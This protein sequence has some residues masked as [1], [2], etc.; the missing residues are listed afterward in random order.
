MP[1]ETLEH[2]LSHRITALFQKYRHGH[3]IED[4][5]IR[6]EVLAECAGVIS[7]EDREMIPE[8]LVAV[9]KTGFKS[10]LQSNFKEL[11]GFRVR[12]RFSLAH[13]IA[14]TFFYEEVDGVLKPMRDAPRGSNLESA[15]HQAAGLLLVPDTCLSKE[16]AKSSNGFTLEDVLPLSRTFD[17]S[18]EVML[19]RLAQ[20]GV[21]DAARIAPI[22]TRAGII[23]FALYPPELKSCLS[24]PVRGTDF[25][26]WFGKRA[27]QIETL[28]DG[29]LRRIS[30]EGVV[31]AREIHITSER[32]LWELKRC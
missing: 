22:L 30:R 20:H 4:L 27:R 9:E 25:T 32:R 7:I 19:R 13:E 5:P 24:E 26:E 6:L 15:C 12:R 17:V 28:Q 10:Y 1:L 3:L 16:L 8:A 2:F 29:S 23:E 18:A 14:H 21:F 31:L 11:P